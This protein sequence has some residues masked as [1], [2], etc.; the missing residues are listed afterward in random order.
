VQHPQVRKHF[1]QL[2]LNKNHGDTLKVLLNFPELF[3]NVPKENDAHESLDQVNSLQILDS[4]LF[5]SF[6]NGHLQPDVT[7]FTSPSTN[8]YR[9]WMNALLIRIFTSSHSRIIVVLLY[10][11]PR[12]QSIFHIR[13][14]VQYLTISLLLTMNLLAT[15]IRS[16]PFSISMTILA[17]T[18]SSQISYPLP[19]TTRPMDLTI[20]SNLFPLRI[21]PF[22]K[23]VFN[24]TPHRLMVAL[25]AVLPPTEIKWITFVLPIQVWVSLCLY[26]MPENTSTVLK[27]LEI[28]VLKRGLMAKHLNR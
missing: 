17:M 12:Q 4:K 26:T 6:N 27:A 21:S 15:A 5:T 10:T 22:I 3:D 18:S 19:P 8:I 7:Q 2:L 28:S 24:V 25:I 9:H 20:Q 11:T 14:F 16:R 13:M 1:Q 23:S